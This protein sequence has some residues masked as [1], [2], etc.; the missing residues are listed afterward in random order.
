ME[1]FSVVNYNMATNPF[2][3]ASEV[4][5]HMRAFRRRGKRDDHVC[6]QQR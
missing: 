4:T 1:V 2:N 5:R 3:T 6:L